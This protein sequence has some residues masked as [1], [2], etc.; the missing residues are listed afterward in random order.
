MRKCDNCIYGSYGLDCNDGTEALYCGIYGYE[1]DV[2]PGYMC[3]DHQF[4]DGLGNEKNYIL[5]DDTYLGKGYFII[6]EINNKI[7]K[8]IKIYTINNNGFNHYC[9]RAYGIESRDNPNSDYTNIEFVFRSMEDFSNGLYNVF[10]ELV[11]NING[12]ITTTD[13]Y[14]E[15]NNNISFI[16]NDK[17]II[18]IVI[19]K[20]IWRGRQH[21][22]DYIDINIGDNYTCKNYE[23]INNFYNMLSELSCDKTVNNNIKRI[24]E[25]KI[26]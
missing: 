9:L 23:A 15:G 18:R 16:L 11:K 19:S 8:F 20:D 13:E 10:L 7:K 26:K 17:G 6:N 2:M 5:Y 25:L 24:L 14:Y 22:T 3:P 1:S 12:N 21:P 4:I